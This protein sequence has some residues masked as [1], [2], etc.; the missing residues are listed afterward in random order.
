MGL[1][2]TRSRRHGANMVKQRP[3]LGKRV[4][5]VSSVPV[6]D[7]V[8]RLLEGTEA[9]RN[10]PKQ[11]QIG[12][13]IWAVVCKQVHRDFDAKQQTELVY[14]TLKMEIFYFFSLFLRN[15]VARSLI[16]LSIIPE[17]NGF[18]ISAQK[19]RL[20]LKTNYIK[21]NEIIMIM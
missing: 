16:I 1:D 5:T 3:T 14:C 21:I 7:A 13:T 17:T 4:P 10:P 6:R 18:V 8:L 12:F 15:P 20:I 2:P 19:L 11:E 9:E